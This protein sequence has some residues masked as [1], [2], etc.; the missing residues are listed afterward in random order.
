M[1]ASINLCI[2]NTNLNEKDNIKYLRIIIDSSL[3]WKKQVKSILTDKNEEKYRY[4]IKTP[5]LCTSRSS[6]KSILLIYT[7]IPY[8]W[9]RCMG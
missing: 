9:T 2:N 3:N 5:L 4:S 8:I 7:S 6:Y 1:E